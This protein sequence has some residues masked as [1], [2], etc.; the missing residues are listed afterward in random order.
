M[1]QIEHMD[2]SR[3]W[4]VLSVILVDDEGMIPIQ[5][6]CFGKHEPTDVI[7]LAYDPMPP[8][9]DVYS[10]EI[11]VNVQRAYEVGSPNGCSRELALYLA[12]GCQHL[13]GISDDT[14]IQ[15]AK[16]RRRENAWLK[17]ADLQGLWTN[18]MGEK[19]SSSEP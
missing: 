8:D 16:M 15:R 9:F 1:E 4:S 17:D 2:S 14:P 13:T 7:S 10:G 11:I 6:A 12:H 3:R 18:L 19:M 5:R